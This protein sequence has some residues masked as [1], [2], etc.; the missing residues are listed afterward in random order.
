MRNVCS[1]LSADNVLEDLTVKFSSSCS[2]L[3]S[4]RCLTRQPSC[5][6]LR[7]LFVLQGLGGCCSKHIDRGWSLQGRTPPWIKMSHAP[8]VSQQ[9]KMS[10]LSNT[11]C[12]EHWAVGTN[13]KAEYS[14]GFLI[15]FIWSRRKTVVNLLAV[16]LNSAE[17]SH[18]Q[19]FFVRRVNVFLVSPIFWENYFPI[20]YVGS[21][22][23][24]MLP[25]TSLS[26]A[27]HLWHFWKPGKTFLSSLALWKPLLSFWCKW[28]EL[29]IQATGQG[30]VP[31]FT[32]LCCGVGWRLP[33]LRS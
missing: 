33:L 11:H 13:W 17:A 16:I 21:P 12:R 23:R 24:N 7:L 1:W 6:Y 2:S 20:L 10:A 30:K 29:M 9:Y 15:F 14:P 8:P 28:I 19:V 25:G 18:G 4:W 26:L 31:S 27:F 22:Q 5:W 32:A 3:G